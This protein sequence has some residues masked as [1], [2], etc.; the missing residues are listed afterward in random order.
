V[1]LGVR[2]NTEPGALISQC[3]HQ[4]GTSS[5]AQRQRA[6]SQQRPDQTAL[7]TA[8]DNF[9]SRGLTRIGDANRDR[10]TAAANI[11]TTLYYP[12]QS[13]IRCGVHQGPGKRRRAWVS[14]IQKPS[15]SSALAARPGYKALRCD[16][17]RLLDYAVGLTRECR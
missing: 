15:H 6:R 16:K 7:A 8:G 13:C 3:R 9:S 2:R 4:H 12:M 10:F 17:V 14:P 11:C 5:A 1:G